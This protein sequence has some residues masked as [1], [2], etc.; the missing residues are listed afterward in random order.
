[1]NNFN[2]SDLIYVKYNVISGALCNNIIQLYEDN[3]IEHILTDKNFNIICKTDKYCI[4]IT[5][6]LY[7]EL[8]KHIDIY[9]KNINTTSIPKFKI[10][11]LNSLYLMNND[12]IIEKHNV[13]N[14]M[15]YLK[16]KIEMNAKNKYESKILEYIFFLNKYEGEI[17]F[18]GDYKI[19]PEPGMLLVFPASWC[20][21]RTDYIKEGMTRY[22]IRGYINSII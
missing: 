7:D 16:S 15:V 14:D 18:I 17:L 21:T 10:L 2:M 13:T 8:Y 3:I 19:I 22:T 11:L 1:M 20:F 6:L 9:V 4:K 12:L 5:E